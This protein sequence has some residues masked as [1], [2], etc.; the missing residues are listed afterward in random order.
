M[1]FEGDGV[2]D[3]ATSSR[4]SPQFTYTTQWLYFP[5]VTIT[6]QDG[7]RYTTTTLVNVVS[8]PDLQAKWAAMKAALLKGDIEGAL[9]FFEHRAR[10]RF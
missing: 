5:T 9:Q 1:D 8:L 6:A 4:P 10:E 2:V 7:T 3:L